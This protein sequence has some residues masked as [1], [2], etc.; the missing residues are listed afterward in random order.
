MLLWLKFSKVC[1]CPFNVYATELMSHKYWSL[2]PVHRFKS[3]SNPTFDLLAV[4]LPLFNMKIQRNLSNE[5]LRWFDWAPQVQTDGRTRI[6]NLIKLYSI[7]NISHLHCRNFSSQHF[8]FGTKLRGRGDA[9]FLCLMYWN[10]S[11]YIQLLGVYKS[12][13]RTYYEMEKG[14]IISTF[15]SIYLMNE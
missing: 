7:Y 1:L 14:K 15:Y 6:N 12:R 8:H 9:T 11:V 13:S 5:N 3:F 10:A 4:Q 2:L